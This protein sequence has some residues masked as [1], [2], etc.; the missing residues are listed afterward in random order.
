MKVSV[1]LATYNSSRFLREQL[2]SLLN[3]TFKNW[4]LIIRDDGSTDS[5]LSIIDEYTRFHK[6][7]K[8]MEDSVLNKGAKESFM[9]LLMSTDSDYYFFCDH[10]DVWLPDKIK[11]TMDIMIKLESENPGRALIVH[12]DLRVVNENLLEASESFWKSSRIY[13]AILEN[14]NYIQVFN[15]VTGCTM[16]FNRKVKE[17]SLPYPVSI[18]MHD[19]WL[20][21]ATLRNGGL[22]QHITEPTIL[23][24]QHDS[25]EVGARSVDRS[26]FGRKLRNIAKTLDGQ[27]EIRDFLKDINGLNVIQYYYYK[28]LYSIQRILK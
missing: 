8:V 1:L 11:S 3:Q 5:T 20:A 17:V 6:N 26:Y 22:I 27:K 13:P 28:I 7:I 25:N 10:D 2:D 24:R 18:P 16:A 15:C 4:E 19:W 14:K 12:S 21:I 23:Y 9:W